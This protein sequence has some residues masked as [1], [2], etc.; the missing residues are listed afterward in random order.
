MLT[1]AGLLFLFSGASKL[2]ENKYPPGLLN[3]SVA[4]SAPPGMITGGVIEPPHPGPGGPNPHLYTAPM[5]GPYGRPRDVSQAHSRFARDGML[6]TS[7]HDPMYAWPT[8]PGG[9]PPK[10]RRRIA[11]PQIRRDATI[12][13][14]DPEIG[15]REITVDHDPYRTAARRLMEKIKPRDTLFNAA[16]EIAVTAGELD[17]R[18]NKYEGRKHDRV[19]ASVMFGPLNMQKKR[20]QRESGRCVENMRMPGADK[21]FA[22]DSM[23]VVARSGVSSSTRR[24]DDM[25]VLRTEVKPMITTNLLEGTSYGNDRM[26]DKS[27]EYVLS[28]DPTRNPVVGNVGFV[29]PR[30]IVAEWKER[31]AREYEPRA[32]Y[33][34]YKGLV[35]VPNTMD[36]G[37]ETRNGRVGHLD[38]W[39]VRPMSES[40]KIQHPYNFS[41]K[42]HS[43]DR[44]LTNQRLLPNVRSAVTGDAEI[45][46]VDGRQ[47]TT[48]NGMEAARIAG[49]PVLTSGSGIQAQA[50]MRRAKAVTTGLDQTNLHKG[51]HEA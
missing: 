11:D 4:G 3:G 44:G 46:N 37:Q 38:A 30:F 35:D 22:A 28:R 33:G 10:P 2:Y 7:R 29:A 12:N 20:A 1:A 19:P 39:K 17:D 45:R 47:Q 40:S 48:R 34:S 13:R 24:A 42:F 6:A 21:L 26:P 50:D 23:S 49:P 14:S 51:Q 8:K 16:G 27:R 41:K 5:V 15:F 36:A 43:K 25:I 9:G 32:S 31:Q 18:V